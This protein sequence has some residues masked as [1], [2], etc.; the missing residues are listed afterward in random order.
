MHK[1]TYRHCIADGTPYE[2]G[3]K[4]GSQL[5]EDK[6]LIKAI[7]TPLF[8]QPLPKK[9]VEETA[10]LFE[11]FIPG[12]NEEIKG[13]SDAANVSYTDMVIYSSYINIPGGCSHFVILHENSQ[14]NEIIHARNYDYD[15]SEVPILIT[16]RTSGKNYNTG[17]NCKIFG[18]FDG[19][20][21]QGLCITTSSVDLKH[22]GRMCNGFVFPMIVRAMLEQCSCTYEAKEMLMG[23]PYAEY[24]N[25]LLSDKSG[26]AM[27]I[28]V[29]PDKKLVKNINV[30]NQYGFL[31]SAN[32]FILEQDSDLQPVRH[33]IVRQQQMEQALSSGKTMTLEDVKAFLGTRYPN[34]LAFP[35]YREGMGTLWSAIYEPA[36]S[37]Q[38]ICYG[39]PESGKWEFIKHNEKEGCKKEVIALFD[40]E[41]PK[42]FWV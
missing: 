36:R 2:V 16:A 5:S 11:K 32:H 25:F 29:S 17:F 6:N 21:E 19:M 10:A 27:L 1:I 28:E 20:N 34:G 18:R 41:A 23:I 8:G 13:F 4:L 33:S 7:T 31:C 30:D 35:Y 22:T 38:H 26:T 37:V 42:E 9:Q 40:V 39:S 3:F 15:Y 12:I 14:G 24:R